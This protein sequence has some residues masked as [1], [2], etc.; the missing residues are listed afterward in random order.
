MNRVPKLHEFFKP[1]SDEY[2]AIVHAYYHFLQFER[3][4]RFKALGIITHADPDIIK[5]WADHAK[6]HYSAYENQA[7]HMP[8]MIEYVDD[9][10]WE[11]IEKRMHIM[12]KEH[13]PEEKARREK[14]ARKKQREF[15]RGKKARYN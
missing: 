15:E 1:G 10:A 6:Y 9:R 12:T 2:K 8:T 14:L 7:N 13:P 4:E 3:G 11:N 5:Y